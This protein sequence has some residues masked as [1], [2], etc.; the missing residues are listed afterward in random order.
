MKKVYIF[1]MMAALALLSSCSSDENMNVA[2]ATSENPS[3]LIPIRMNVGRN[4]VIVTRGTGTVGD[5]AKAKNV[6]QA[7]HINV[8]MLN[9]GTMDLALFNGTPIYENADFWTPGLTENESDIFKGITTGVDSKGIARPT[10]DLIKYYPTQGNFDFWGYRLDRAATAA[11]VKT[12]NAWT[13]DFKIDGS[14]DVMVAKAIPSTEELDAVDDQNLRS[15]V[16]RRAYSGFAARHGLQPTLNF[17]HLL[18]RFT[19]SVVPKHSNTIDATSGISVDSISIASFT[20][21]T[22]TIAALND[23]NND[24]QAIAWDNTGARDTIFLKQRA[25][26]DN[27]AALTDSLD[28]VKL[29]PVDLKGKAKDV[30]IKVGESILACPDSIYRIRV[31]LSQML[32][33][34]YSN[35]TSLQLKKY[36]YDDYL[37]LRDNTGNIRRDTNGDIEMFQPGYS[38]NVQISLWGLEEIKVTTTLG[39][40]LDGGE[41][42][43]QPE[44]EDDVPNLEP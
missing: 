4:S 5:T 27:P 25:V 40:W 3:E 18:S 11:P 17:K 34:Y 23:D 33:E 14:Q 30:A 12:A 42:Q 9:K 39:K 6:W 43:L 32:P 26:A 31:Y 16:Q 15:D 37:V 8:Y 7:Q 28:L 13:V 10:N 36:Y 41:I 29:V 19:F 2:D 44:E 21:G 24:K 38:Y 1:S 35:S 22:L 20:K